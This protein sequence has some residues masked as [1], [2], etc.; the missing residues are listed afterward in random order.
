MIGMHACSVLLA[1]GTPKVGSCVYCAP[2][3]ASTLSLETLA[4]ADPSS[5]SSSTSMSQPASTSSSSTPSTSL[6][7]SSLWNVGDDTSSGLQ[8]VRRRRITMSSSGSNGSE[9]KKD[10]SN[11]MSQR[12][13]TL[14]LPRDLMA[15]IISFIPFNYHLPSRLRERPAES[16][17]A[18]C[19]ADEPE[20]IPTPIPWDN[21]PYWVCHRW[22]DISTWAPT[23]LHLEW[24]LSGHLYAIK[25]V[26]N[27]M[28]GAT[29]LI[30]SGQSAA[31]QRQKAL[32]EYA[33]HLPLRRLGLYTMG[34]LEVDDLMRTFPRLCHLECWGLS[35]SER[36]E[37]TTAFRI[38]L[39]TSVDQ[40]RDAKICPFPVPR[41]ACRF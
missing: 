29:S 1:F 23:H 13:L 35:T 11:A 16:W 21:T 34:I 8:Q 24:C 27:V 30:L 9:A 36:Q 12:D 38:R 2:R 32:L 25:Q 33:S 6:S 4:I 3:M 18:V 31:G 40:S 19:C 15:H 20:N 37:L 17:G 7:L 26:L 28:N 5:P 22:Q 10:D 39:A 14:R 41:C